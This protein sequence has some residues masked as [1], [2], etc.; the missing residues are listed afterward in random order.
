MFD[1]RSYYSQLGAHQQPETRAAIYPYSSNPMTAQM[2]A[3][4]GAAPSLKTSYE[5]DVTGAA[6]T[7]AFSGAPNY[8]GAL[9]LTRKNN[10]H[11]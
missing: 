2:E 10:L 6:A 7:G 11:C 1:V 8:V 9:S 3:F 5:T 4:F